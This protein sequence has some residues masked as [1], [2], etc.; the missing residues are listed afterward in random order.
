MPNIGNTLNTGHKLN[1]YKTSKW[2]RERHLNMLRMFSLQLVSRGNELRAKL[3]VSFK[4][5]VFN[6]LSFYFDSNYLETGALEV[7]SV[8]SDNSLHNV[9]IWF[10]KLN[11]LPCITLA[12][13]FWKK[14][15]PRF[16]LKV[17]NRLLWW[18]CSKNNPP[19][20][21]IINKQEGFD[22][23]GGHRKPPWNALTSKPQIW[24]VLKTMR[25][26][27]DYGILFQKKYVQ[28]WDIQ[29]NSVLPAI[30]TF[31]VRKFPVITF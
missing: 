7:A 5:C 13:Y 22:F 24:K 14:I 8:I 12:H 28:Q 10:W 23:L 31:F 11:D 2:C 6:L 1:V 21:K 3:R 4:N 30:F 19:L 18:M 29:L 9:L 20:P 16:L 26:N 27:K 25:C 15:Y 17:L